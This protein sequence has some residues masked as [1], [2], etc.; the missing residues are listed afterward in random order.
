MSLATV[1]RERLQQRVHRSGQLGWAASVVVEFTT[2]SEA[3]LSQTTVVA[4]PMQ[5]AIVVPSLKEVA[6]KQCI[7]LDITGN[8]ATLS[9]GMLTQPYVV[10]AGNAGTL[11]P[12]PPWASDS[13]TS[14]PAACPHHKNPPN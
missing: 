14:R 1:A 8:A 11:N 3:D 4:C 6:Y 5:P 9:G 13:S 12:K 2:P 10:L 7:A